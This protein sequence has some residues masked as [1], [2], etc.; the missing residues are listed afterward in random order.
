MLTLFLLTGIPVNAQG[1]SVEKT[2]I[3][4]PAQASEKPTSSPPGIVRS[5]ES[6]IKNIKTRSESLTKMA[7]NM[8]AKFDS[9]LSNVV[10]YYTGTVIPSGK[11]VANYQNLINDANTKR[12]AVE[13]AL[14]T[15][16][17]DLPT[18]SCDNDNPK[19]AV[20]RFNKDMRAVKTALAN[21]RTSIKNVI[22][23]VHGFRRPTSSPR[24]F[25]PRESLKPKPPLSPR[26]ERT[27]GPVRNP[28]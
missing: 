17:G 24:Q 16:T 23:A 28:I 5:C 12:A 11:T 18:L 27:V 6:A 15:A 2:S 19:D 4:R 21:Y 14:N 20:S 26:P 3:F 9:I 1:R 7:K 25:L 13:T 22:K 10:N 8:L